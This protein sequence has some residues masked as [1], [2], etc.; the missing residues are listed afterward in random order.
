LHAALEDFTDQIAL[1]TGASS[2][3]GQAIAAE[4]LR[5]GACVW[6]VGRQRSSLE[7]ALGAE[8]SRLRHL[9][10][11]LSSDA[12]ISTLS[13]VLDSAEALD[14]LVHSAGQIRHGR[15]ASV[16]LDHFDEQYRVNLRAPFA[17]TQR[18]LPA[19]IRSR[20]QVVFINS[21]SGVRASVEA[22]QYS[23]T[24][25]GL[26]GLAEALRDEV[27]PAGV[28]VL[29]VFVG[30]TATPMQEAVFAHEG[31]PWDPAKVLQPGE[32]AEWVV[33]ALG[34]TRSAELF[35]IHMRPASKP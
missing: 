17:I 24:K 14:I 29:T 11:D 21:V 30:R 32:V 26:R 34:T 22:A 33:C 35:E 4:L 1:V 10:A 20:G 23:A 2:G 28:R 27:S 19:L 16:T 15:F 25:F 18:A 8:N 3:I 13:A 6:A 9:E 12:G 5:R 7:T 31:R